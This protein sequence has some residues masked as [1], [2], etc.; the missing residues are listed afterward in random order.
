MYKKIA[1]IGVGQCG[2]NHAE[3]ADEIGFSITG[4]INTSEQD[5][6]PLKIKNKLVV[7]TTGGCA[8]DLKVGVQIFENESEKI[9][10]FIKNTSGKASHV[11]ITFSMGGGTGASIGPLVCK[12][13]KNSGVGVTALLAST[14]LSEAGL[15]YSNE[16]SVIKELMSSQIPMMII[17]NSKIILSEKKSQYEKLNTSVLNKLKTFLEEKQGNMNGNMDSAEKL[18]LLSIPGLIQISHTRVLNETD[19]NKTIFE[20][21]NDSKAN[22]FLE[23]DILPKASGHIF[24]TSTK[25][26]DVDFDK[27]YGDNKPARIYEGFVQGPP[28]DFR[29]INILAGLPYPKKRIGMLTEKI[30]ETKKVIIKQKQVEEEMNSL[31]DG[32]ETLDLDSDVVVP[33]PLNSSSF[34]DLNDLLK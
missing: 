33:K 29:V 34:D 30:T 11:I 24:Y 26:K 9:M 6:A 8:K 27:I 20:S 12:A 21:F 25:S 5:L 7:G 4:A 13:L 32:L 23:T 3:K 15:A 19:V 2:G 1:V 17:D 10:K 22:I 18:A 14:G 31:F 28:N 16:I